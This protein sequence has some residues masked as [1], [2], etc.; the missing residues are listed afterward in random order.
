MARHTEGGTEV[1]VEDINSTALEGEMEKELDDEEGA[2]TV[3]G[4]PEEELDDEDEAPLDDDDD[5][6]LDDV[7][8]DE[9]EGPATDKKEDAEEVAE[10]PIAREDG[11]TFNEEAGRWQKD[12]KFVE[13]EKPTAELE[14]RATARAAAEKPVADAA[15][16]AGAAKPGAGAAAGAAAPGKWEQFSVKADRKDHAIDEAVVRREG[17]FV[18]LGIPEDK[19]NTFTNRLGAGIVAQRMTR[20]LDQSLKDLETAK[21]ELESDRKFLDRPAGATWNV[22]KTAW[23]DA[24]GAVVQGRPPSATE[25]EAMIWLDAIKPKID[26]L[27]EPIEIDNFALKVKLAQQGAA[28]ATGRFETERK[29]KAT[30]ANQAEETQENGLANTIVEV[31]EAFPEFKDLTDDHLREVLG[32]LR[33]YKRSLYYQEGGAWFKNTEAVHAALKRKVE[34]LAKASPAAPAPA[35][36]APAADKAD[37]FNA[38][39]DSAAKPKT[40]SVAAQRGA[41]P[42]GQRPSREERRRKKARGKTREQRDEDQYRKVERAFMASPGL[43]FPEE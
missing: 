23:V 40:T 36:P 21:A 5:D 34:A 29:T 15:V 9:D 11:A 7:L 22:D 39:Q 2:E 30:E 24:A 38:G 3:E 12:G 10:P 42:A 25:I 26:G 18:F 19:F 20:E 33:P 32:E 14:K 8:D 17:G 13:G 37:R 6:D 27:F 43:D 35:K 28:G 31:A 41:R 1:E 16:A 4:E